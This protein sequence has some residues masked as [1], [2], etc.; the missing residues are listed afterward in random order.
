[1]IAL[2]G[3][4]TSSNLLPQWGGITHEGPDAAAEIATQIR[5]RRCG[6]KPSESAKRDV[7]GR[8]AAKNPQQISLRQICGIAPIHY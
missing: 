4:K 5:V 2:Q 6:A 8:W 7:F 3:D 1:M